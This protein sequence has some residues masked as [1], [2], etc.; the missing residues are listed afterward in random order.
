M[1]K[2]NVATEVKI[3]DG[4]DNINT[5]TIVRVGLDFKGEV[6]ARDEHVFYPLIGST[7][8]DGT[9]DRHIAY[10]FGASGSGKTT[11]ASNIGYVYKRR[12]PASNVVLISVLTD[13]DAYNRIPGLV[14]VTP[15][16]IQAS[17][18]TLEDYLE[19]NRRNLFILDDVDTMVKEDKQF[20]DR[21]AL[22]IQEIGRHFEISM[23]RISHIPNKYQET[24]SIL[25]ESHWL[26]CFP[27]FQSP[28]T[29]MPLF[30]NHLGLSQRDTLPIWSYPEDG[31]WVAVHTHVPMVM[32]TRK[33]IKSLGINIKDLIS[34][35][36]EKIND[37]NN[38]F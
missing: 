6:P 22:K 12:F 38:F 32:I 36:E 5:K 13:D 27:H 10:I 2:I 1:E 29:L 14:Q 33:R 28:G 34:K 24:R 8:P 9:I 37:K 19:Y 7:K 17:F 3:V 23:L 15:G 35:E 30:K 16:E 4:G 11:V 21:L 18:E 20:M 25:R 26:I 31:R